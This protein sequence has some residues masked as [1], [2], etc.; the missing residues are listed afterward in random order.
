[1]AD[2]AWPP[3]KQEIDHAGNPVEI[4]PL[5]T[6]AGAD[7]H[8]L[9]V[10]LRS[11]LGAVVYETGGLLIDH[12]WVR[13]LGSGSD[14]LGRS[15]VSWNLACGLTVPGDTLLLVGD[16]AV[17]G[18]FAINA[19]RFAGQPGEVHYF[20]PDTLS[21]EALGRGYSDFIAFLLNGD[22]AEFYANARWNGWE[23]EIVAMAGHQALSIYPPLWAKASSI[24]ERSRRP[25]P[26]QELVGLTGSLELLP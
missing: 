17:G 25:V 13:L 22:L 5:G 10:S 11:T 7:L 19:G 3:L 21:W 16:D 12:G 8:R 1:V 20:A 15:L 24:D 6:S 18:L 14:R 4:L 2:P 9:Q 23:A 26:L